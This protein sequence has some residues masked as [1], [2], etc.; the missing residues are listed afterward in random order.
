MLSGEGN[1]STINKD[2]GQIN[3][4]TSTLHIIFRPKLQN[5]H[6]TCSLSTTLLNKATHYL[7]SNPSTYLDMSKLSKEQYSNTPLTSQDILSHLLSQEE[8]NRTYSH[9]A[10][11]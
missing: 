10:H 4:K 1:K 9:S 5:L 6:Q 8:T 11:Q 7:Q 2:S 3:Y